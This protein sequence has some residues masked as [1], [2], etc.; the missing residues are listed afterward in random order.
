MTLLTPKDFVG[1][2]CSTF[3]VGQNSNGRFRFNQCQFGTMPIPKF[4]VNG[5]LKR[6]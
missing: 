1:F 3:D 2:K 6:A 5:G 4:D